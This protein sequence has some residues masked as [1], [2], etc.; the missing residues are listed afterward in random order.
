MSSS[1]NILRV[2]PEIED[3]T[4]HTAGPNPLCPYTSHQSRQSVPSSLVTSARNLYII[5]RRQPQRCSRFVG[6]GGFATSPPSNAFDELVQVLELEEVAARDVDEDDESEFEPEPIP[7]RSSKRLEAAKRKYTTTP[8]SEPASKHKPARKAASAASLPPAKRRRPT[9]TSV[10]TVEEREKA[11]HFLSL[12]DA[13]KYARGLKLTIPSEI[14]KTAEL[15]YK[16]LANSRLR[17]PIEAFEIWE[18]QEPQDRDAIQRWKNS[19]RMR[20]SENWPLIDNMTKEERHEALYLIPNTTLRK[21]LLASRERVK[22][23]AT[24][25]KD[26]LVQKLTDFGAKIPDACYDD[27]SK[28]TKG[29]VAFKGHHRVLPRLYRAT[30]REVAQWTLANL[31]TERDPAFGRFMQDVRR[32]FDTFIAANASTGKASTGK[33]RPGTS[34][35]AITIPYQCFPQIGSQ[36]KPPSHPHGSTHARGSLHT[37]DQTSDTDGPWNRSCRLQVCRC[38]DG[39]NACA[40]TASDDSVDSRQAA[41]CPFHDPAWKWLEAGSPRRQLR[42]TEPARCC[43][44]SRT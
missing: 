9:L 17:V 38:V 27:W 13:L 19:E 40:A 29:K 39:T 4:E 22:G 44:A 25:K 41:G 6:G 20:S 10:L 7:V 16:L 15:V 31:K 33:E 35:I 42:E 5:R 11:F 2:K 21:M 24:P 30:V 12:R 18:R 14:E 26:I 36:V 43:P 32:K 3:L 1:S 34:P 28:G 8:A 37:S 23:K